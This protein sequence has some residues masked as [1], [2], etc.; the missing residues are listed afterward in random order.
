MSEIAAKKHSRFGIASCVIGVFNL[1]YVG[2]WVFGWLGIFNRLVGDGPVL[3]LLVVPLIFLVGGLGILTGILGG[4]GGLFESGR[5]R[6]FAV[7]GLVINLVPPAIL[8]YF[9]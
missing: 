3:G 5:N 2:E 7:I 4:I 9:F 8:L 6:L 1:V